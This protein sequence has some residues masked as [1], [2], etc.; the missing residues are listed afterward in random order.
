MQ[1]IRVT[2]AKPYDVVIGK[3]LLAEAPARIAAV[4]KT[5]NVM[6]VSDD[7]VAPLY[8]VALQ[9]SLAEAGFFAVPFVFPNGEAQKRLS[10][11][12]RL[13]EEM[14]AQH[15]GRGDLV[16]ALGGGVVGDMAGFA[17]AVYARGIDYVQIPTTLLAA[18]DSSVGGKTA[19]DLA[20]GKNL[21]G[22]FHQPRLVLCDTDTHKTLQPL[23]I[24]DGLAEMLKYGVICDSDLFA[25]VKNYKNE[26]MEA[27]I[28]RCVEIKRDVVAADEFDRG[29]RMLLN[30]GHTVGHAIEAASDFAVTHGHGVAIGMAI[31]A[32][33]AEKKGMAKAGTAKAVEDALTACGLPSSTDLTPETLADHAL[34]DKKAEGG[35]L[36]LILPRAVGDTVIH[37]IP[38]TY[39]ELVDFIKAGV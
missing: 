21:C 38:K 29:Q 36:S 22:A 14:A 10:T 11:V 30:L 9:R 35:F 33:A 19:V 12:E 34:S 27:L 25:K 8:G 2:T 13:L 17:A 39:F 18:V 32:R 37:R 26:D 24:C 4:C 5:K 6:L 20:G 28:A 3:G 23:Q 31:V 16:I 7:I 15:F 1:T